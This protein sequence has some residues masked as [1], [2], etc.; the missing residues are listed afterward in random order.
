MIDLRRR[1]VETRADV[2]GFK[3]GIISKNFRLGSSMRQQFEHVFNPD[4]HTP[5]AGTS[6][7][8][9]WGDTIQIGHTQDSKLS[10]S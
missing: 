2:F 7:A 10:T 9:T 4:A 3:I 6:T 8:L 1:I 5:Y